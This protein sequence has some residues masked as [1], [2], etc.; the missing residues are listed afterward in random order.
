[1]LQ[2]INIL[3][4]VII[5][6]NRIKGIHNSYLSQLEEEI[7][8][9][10]ATKDEI[11]NIDKIIYK[12]L[13]DLIYNISMRNIFSKDNKINYKNYNDIIYDYDFI[14]EELGKII[15]PG[16]KKF[17]KGK[18]KFITYLFEGFRGE[19]SSVLVDYNVKYKQR[20]LIN[21]EKNLLFKLSKENN[22]NN[23]NNDVFSSLQILMKEIIKENYELNFLI[24]K[25]IESLPE[26]IILNNELKNMFINTYNFGNKHFFSIDT[27][28]PIFEYFEALCWKSMKNNILPDYRLKVPEEALKNINEY[29]KNNNKKLINI[30]NFTIALRKL[31]SRA[32]TGTRQEIEINPQNKLQLYLGKEELWQKSI[33][34]NDEFE[35]EINNICKNDLIIGYCLD[36]YDSL[37]GDDI[38]KNEINWD[39]E[40]KKEDNDDKLLNEEEDE[41]DDNYDERNEI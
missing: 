31:I 37:K 16:I 20:E 14:E 18:I 9:Q 38:L 24:F 7:N 10:E 15:L 11:I 41:F 34:E 35:I 27:L 1:M 39:N 13:N 23:F 17:K 32:L 8:I 26:Y 5:G 2:R 28:V 33:T 19:N 3:L 4:N 22:S 36:I 29:F 6:S 40:N 21:E 12:V 30:N 25:V